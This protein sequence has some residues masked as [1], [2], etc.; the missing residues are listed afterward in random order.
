M[1]SKWIT[2]SQHREPNPNLKVRPGAFSN[3]L[4]SS[5]H[6]PDNNISREKNP[7]NASFDIASKAPTYINNENETH[8][9]IPEAHRQ[10]AKFEQQ[11]LGNNSTSRPLGERNINQVAP[12]DPKSQSHTYTVRHSTNEKQ[13]KSGE[14]YTLVPQRQGSHSKLAQNSPSMNRGSTSKSPAGYS[15]RKGSLVQT[16]GTSGKRTI[17]HNENEENNNGVSQS[18]VTRSQSTLALR[19]SSESKSHNPRVTQQRSEGHLPT[20]QESQEIHKLKKEN[21]DLWNNMNKINGE[22]Q[23]EKKKCALL[24]GEVE[25]FKNDLV[26]ERE[27]Y[28]EELFKISQQIKKLRNIQNIY[29]TEKKN[30]EKLENQ[31]NL[32][33]KSLSD[34]SHLLW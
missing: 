23:N 30:S 19:P 9:P 17:R 6:V 7:R 34:I 32:K 10:S 8:T 3:H 5:Y 14:N 12:R 27:K 15:N 22:L 25:N 31:L 13:N 18:K 1:Q 21:Q 16:P 33:E 28:K 26:K 11:G 20:E 29:V 24:E 2:T 4:V